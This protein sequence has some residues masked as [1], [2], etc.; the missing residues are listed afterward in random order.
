MFYEN[1]AAFSSMTLFLIKRTEHY[2]QDLFGH[3]LKESCCAL[4]QDSKPGLFGTFRA[5]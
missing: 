3:H 5:G 4:S 1:L 2:P